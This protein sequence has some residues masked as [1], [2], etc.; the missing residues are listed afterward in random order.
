MYYRLMRVHLNDRASR[1]PVLVF[2]LWS[3]ASVTGYEI[4]LTIPAKKKANAFAN[5]RDYIGCI[6]DISEWD[7]IFTYIKGYK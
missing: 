7:R 6:Y 4:H 2:D 3:E 1:C 5:A